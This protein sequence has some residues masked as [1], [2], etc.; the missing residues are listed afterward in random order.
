MKRI[1]AILVLAASLLCGSSAYAAGSSSSFTVR[2][3]LNGGGL[4]PVDISAQQQQDFGLEVAA[5]NTARLRRSF[6]RRGVATSALAQ[7]AKERA[8][9]RLVEAGEALAAATLGQARDRDVTDQQAFLISIGAEPSIFAEAVAAARAAN[10]AQFNA[11]FTQFTGLTTEGGAGAPTA[12]P[13]AEPQEETRAERRARR[14]AERRAAR[15]RR[16][17]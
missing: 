16:N 2:G 4:L 8:R 9:L 1:H 15:Q 11:L 5:T 12:E 6:E 14:R 17:R 10:P 13:T 7:A 3:L